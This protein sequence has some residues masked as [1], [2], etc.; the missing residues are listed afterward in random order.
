M[1]FEVGSSAIAKKTALIVDDSSVIR[2]ITKTLL[3]NY[4]FEVTTVNDGVEAVDVYK[5]GKGHFDLII[6]DLEMPVM[7][8]IQVSSSNYSLDFL[9]KQCK[10]KLIN[11][12]IEQ[13]FVLRALFV[14]L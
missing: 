1:A 6:T 2:K 7:N 14:V 11:L 9:I 5:A 8:G 10:K 3:S 13:I 12:D 4:G